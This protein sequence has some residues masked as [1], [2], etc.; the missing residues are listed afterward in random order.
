VR[1]IWSTLVASNPFAEKSDHPLEARAVSWRRRRAKRG[2]SA[3]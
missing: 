3:L 2:S 1:A